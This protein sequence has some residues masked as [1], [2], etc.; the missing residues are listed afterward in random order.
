MSLRPFHLVWLATAALLLAPSAA[1]AAWTVPPTP[2]VE[3]AADS[4]LQ[5]VDCSSANSCI[6]VGS[7]GEFGPAGPT[8]TPLAERWDGTSWQ[9]MPTP[10]L[11]DQGRLSGVSCPW[12]RFCFAVGTLGA[13]FTL[14]PYPPSI[15]T[16][17]VE[18]WNGTRW[19][20]QS[21]PAV[22]TG[23][24]D[25]VSCS[26]IVACTAVG[27]VARRLLPP[28][29]SVDTDTFALRW[30]GAGWHVQPTPNAAGSDFDRLT[31]VSCPLKRTCT[32]V[33]QSDA[34]GVTSPFVTRWF[35]R[36]NAWG[37]QSAPKPDGAEDASLAG[38]SCPVAPVC[39]A[40]GSSRPPVGLETVLA[41]RR[42]GAS[43][44]VLPT[45]PLPPP[46]TGVPQ[47]LLG[48]VSCPTLALCRAVGNS[49]SAAGRVPIAER[50]DGTSWQYESIPARP[51]PSLAGV[52][53]PSRFFCMA[54]GS[55][56]PGE[57]GAT[58]SAKWTP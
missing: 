23:E 21:T 3:G 17:L 1:S 41:E 43:W 4:R 46:S 10:G 58:L 47:S 49:T 6:A 35:G 42:I 36:V 9:I 15:S 14:P 22:P 24:L 19:S 55:Y 53:C 38:V 26:G 54:V 44:S 57:V 50:F 11:P 45:P 29:P 56:T 30:E 5:A 25:A 37:L 2:N 33:G 39:V 34:G 13:L 8:V 51:D 48:A 32:A 52:S 12:P 28:P 27:T 18:V 20:I 40:V 16:P 31:A 7:S